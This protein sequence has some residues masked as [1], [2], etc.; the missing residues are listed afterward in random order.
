MK[1]SPTLLAIVLVLSSLVHS[2]ATAADAVEPSLY[3]RLG[4]EPVMTR[5]VEQ[6]IDSVAQDPKV[7]QSFEGVNLQKL[8]AKIVTHVCVLADGGCHY[9]GDGMKLAHEGMNI[10]QRE[11]YAM[12]EALR[13]ALDANGVGEREKNELLRLLAP[14]KRD[15]VSR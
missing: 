11:F 7:N 3:R 6:M 13:V 10:G 4:G 15:V 1:S 8:E 9:T 14:M 2:P 5:V 12:V